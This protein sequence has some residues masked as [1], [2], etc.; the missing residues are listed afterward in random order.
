MRRTNMCWMFCRVRTILIGGLRI[1]TRRC[2]CLSATTMEVREI[3]LPEINW[4]WKLPWALR[5]C[6]APEVSLDHVFLK[7]SLLGQANRTAR[8][9]P[10]Q[11][12][13]A[14]CCSMAGLLI[15]WN[16]QTPKRKRGGCIKWL[17]MQQQCACTWDNDWSDKLQ[18]GLKK[19]TDS[20]HQHLQVVKHA[21]YSSV[22]N[23]IYTVVLMASVALGVIY[24]QKWIHSSDWRLSNCKLFFLYS[25]VPRGVRTRDLRL[26]GPT[27]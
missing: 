27:L 14:M 3:T 16:P 7:L 11:N 20:C 25:S 22:D 23:K 17:Q 18:N 5:T 4:K 19:K 13:S 24:T 6:Y 15:I 2:H 1:S 9:R 12:Q 26:I 21:R 8:G 10:E